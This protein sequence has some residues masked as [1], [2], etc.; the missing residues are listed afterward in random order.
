MCTLNN[1]EEVELAQLLL[2]IHPWAEQVRFAR[3]G[4]EA[5]AIAVRIARAC[6]GRDVIAFCGY[7][8]WHDWYLAANRT[9]QPG[10]DAL[11][12]H[13]LPGP[14]TQRCAHATGRHGPAVQL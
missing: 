8:G 1:P 6:T 4:G 2:R 12:E 3:T 10:Q 13:L 5:M 14:V 7:H 11:Q 9:A